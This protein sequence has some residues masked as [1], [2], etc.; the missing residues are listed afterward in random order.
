LKH[1]LALSESALFS[2]QCDEK[3]GSFITVSNDKLMIYYWRLMIDGFVKSGFFI[4]YEFIV[5]ILLIKL[6][7]QSD[8]PQINNHQSA[9][10]N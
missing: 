10:N 2:K 7:K 5:I 9:I 3:C 6:I 4:F 1:N 8:F